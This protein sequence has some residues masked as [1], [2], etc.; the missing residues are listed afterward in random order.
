MG[1][2]IRKFELHLVRTISIPVHFEGMKHCFVII[3]T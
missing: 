1:V 3:I 2:P